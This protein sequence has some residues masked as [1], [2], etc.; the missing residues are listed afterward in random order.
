VRSVPYS[1]F[2]EQYNKEHLKDFLKR[3]SVYYIPMGDSL[4]AKYEDTSLLFENGAVDFEK[5]IKTA[6]FNEG[7]KRI[8]DGSEKG[9][10]IVLMCS[11]KNPLEC[12]RFSLI[13]H[14]LDKHGYDVE[15][16]LPDKIISHSILDQKLFEYFKDKRKISF[17]I[18]KILSLQGVQ[19]SLFDNIEKRDLYLNLNKMV[20]FNAYS[21]EGNIQ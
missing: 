13:S 15:H 5:V 9:Y 7:I 2:V 8:N 18:E 12:H 1:R 14:F 10:N 6:K 3:N 11:E 19:N 17:E 21:D 4:G 20:A 16:I